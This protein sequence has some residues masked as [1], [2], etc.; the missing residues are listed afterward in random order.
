MPEAFETRLQ[1]ALHEIRRFI[2][3]DGGD[4]R[5]V[6]YNDEEIVVQFLGNCMHCSLKNLTLH[7]GIKA[8]FKKYLPEIK[9]IKELGHE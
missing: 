6:S 3:Q 9:H 2:Q 7:T 8:I 1:K 4:I 5:I